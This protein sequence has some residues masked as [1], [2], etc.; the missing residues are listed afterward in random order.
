MTI[1]RHDMHNTLY[2]CTS[3]HVISPSGVLSQKSKRQ[4]RKKKKRIYYKLEN[5]V[6]ESCFC[7]LTGTLL[8]TIVTDAQ[9]TIRIIVVFLKP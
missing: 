2:G 7:G 5:V 6:W 8:I 1:S 9:N 3:Y 4:P